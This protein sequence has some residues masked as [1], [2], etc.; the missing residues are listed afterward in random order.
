MITLATSRSF[1][2]AVNGNRAASKDVRAIPGARW[3]QKDSTWRIPVA[4]A[5]FVA[6]FSETHRIDMAAEARE[7]IERLHTRR[8]EGVPVPDLDA[9]LRNGRTLF[10]HQ[11]AGVRFL[12]QRRRAILADTMGLG[13][14]LQALVAA[15]CYGIPVHVICPASLRENWAREAEMV[16]VRITTHSWAKVPKT[17]PQPFVLVVDEC[18]M[19]QSGKNSQRGAAF[20]ALSEIAD[21]VFLLSGTPMKNGRPVNLYPLLKAVRSP[22][23]LNKGWYEKRYCDAKP[24]AFS[25]WDTSGA[26]NLDE[27]HRRLKPVMLVRTKEECLDLP[28]KTRVMR[29]A[30][31]TAEA[32]RQYAETYTAAMNRYTEKQLRGEVSEDSEALVRFGFMRQASSVAKVAAACEIA[33]EIT[34]QG[35]QVVI[36]TAF[37][38]SARRIASAFPGSCLLIGETAQDERQ[39]LVD[40]FQ[41]GQSRVFVTTFGA[42]GVGITLTRAQTVILVDRPWTPGDC[43]QAEDRIHRIGQRSNVLSIWLQWD[44]TDKAVDALLESKTERIEVVMA[45]R[46]QTLKQGMTMKQFAELAT[47]K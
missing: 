12:V 37:L 40:R 34:E 3:E 30:D 42:G 26:S 15:Q 35:G 41:A 14:T 44:D 20:L 43:Y 22:L 4:C 13:K 27:L 11:K 17:L 16:G 47:R 45:G 32:K 2:V 21:A 9:P 10:E 46:K 6:E 18:H 28:E 1:A 39:Q 5:Q 38:E 8:A 7:T 36:F 23:A 24:S 33:E 25:S 29:E 31:Q 19:G